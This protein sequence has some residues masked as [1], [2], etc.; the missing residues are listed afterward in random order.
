MPRHPPYALS[1]LTTEIL[2]STNPKGSASSELRFGMRLCKPHFFRSME[3]LFFSKSASQTNCRQSP[4]ARKLPPANL[5]VQRRVAAS[6][7]ECLADRIRCLIN[8][9]TK[10]SKI[11]LTHLLHRAF[12]RTSSLN[13]PVP[14]WKLASSGS[15]IVFGFSRAVKRTKK[16]IFRFFKERL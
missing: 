15:S 3:L 10:L 14:V 7:S 1:N 9:S 5:T 16:N 12:R 4:L 13:Q 6:P 2:N 8:Q 11:K